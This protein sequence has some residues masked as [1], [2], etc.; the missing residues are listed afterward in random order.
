MPFI[1]ESAIR[2]VLKARDTLSRTV[3]QSTASLEALRHQSQSL[4]QQLSKLEQQQGLLSAFEKQKKAVS[5]SSKAFKE[6]ESKVEALAKEY[7]ATDKPTKALEKSLKTARQSVVKANKAYQDQRSKLA[8]LRSGLKEAGLSSTQV[9]QQQ[10]KLSSEIKKTAAAYEKADAKAKKAN[11]TL[12]SNALKNAAKNADKAASSISRLSNRLGALVVAGL[13]LHTIKRGLE[14]ILGTGDKFERLQVQLNAI[15]GSIEGGQQAIT[16]IKDF[17]RNTPFQLEEVSEA[18][19]KLKAF[20]LDP[21]DGTMQALVDQASKLGGGM[22]KLNGIS[23]AVG[24]AWAKQKLQGEEILQLVE[25]GVPVW[26]MLE[27]VTGKNVQELQKLSAAGKLGKDVIADLVAEIGRSAEGAAAENMKL[28]SGYV[29]NLKD[30]WQ[31]FLGEVAK[32]GALEYAKE[33]LKGISDQITLMSADGR[34]STLAKAISDAFITTAESIKATFSN[35]TIDNL[36]LSIQQSFTTINNVLGSMRSAFTFTGSTISFFFNSF[37]L[38]VKSFGLLFSSAVASITQNAAKMFEAFGAS[39]TAEKM[40]KFADGVKAIAAGFK[41]EAAKDIKDVQAAWDS[42]F[43]EFGNKNKQTQ[44]TVRNDNKKTIDELLQNYPKVETA[45][46]DTAETAKVA[47]ADAAD[48]MKQINAAET[49]NDIVDL[50]VA[51][52]QAFADGTLTQEQYN[53]AL[54]ISK[55]KMAELKSAAERSA[56]SAGSAAEKSSK[57]QVAAAKQVT[58]VAG[59]MAAHYSGLSNELNNM[60]GAAQSAFE[61]MQGMD[62]LDTS[63]SQGQVA[64]LKNELKETGDE[65]SR[66]NTTAGT[67][68]PTGID[69]WMNKTAKDAAYVKKQYLEQKIALEELLDGYERGSISAEAFISRGQSA[70]DTMNLLNQQDL[71]RLNSAIQSAEDS[72]S[73]LAESSRSTLDSLKDELDQ[74][75]GKQDDIE[76]RRFENRQRDLKRQRD[77]AKSKGD[78]EALQNLNK[79]LGLSRDIY[80]E[81]RK[82]A[83]EEKQRDFEKQRQQKTRPAATTSTPNQNRNPQKVIRLEYPGGRVNVGIDGKDETKLL[84]ALK[85]AGLKSV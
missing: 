37:T 43:N 19:V 40:Q 85:N 5:E 47:F 83:R 12:K 29:S 61:K 30:S 54:E 73:Q 23:L 27:K 18:F 38:A 33:S 79:A 13:G 4:K 46:K 80:D 1:K 48:A 17:T 20:G 8:Q 53:E 72:M 42:F 51:L 76:R 82:K 44:Q 6:A 10:K 24:Q 62:Q 3:Q 77:E 35:V 64:N 32:S 14:G 68:D 36:V 60:S 81:R 74:L 9:A 67:F 22:E 84:E 58:S 59:A 49:T 50:G 25:R 70:A 52:A 39:D 55:Q 28:L 26:E 69:K 7:N 15:M 16:W 11:R 66:L 57:K 71:D 34:L 56:E 21:M 65:L 75:Q 78:S 63:E 41:E 31:N 2:L 45:V